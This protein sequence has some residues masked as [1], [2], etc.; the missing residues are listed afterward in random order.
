M[1]VT[2]AQLEK[3]TSMVWS[4]ENRNISAAIANLLAVGCHLHRSGNVQVGT[5]CVADALEAVGLH[6]SNKTLYVSYRNALAGNES[7]FASAIQASA[8]VNTWGNGV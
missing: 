6:K 8:E 1:P 5:K 4:H 2:D 7:R 3:I